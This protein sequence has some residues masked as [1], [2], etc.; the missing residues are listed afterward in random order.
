MSTLPKIL[1]TEDLPVSEAKWV[2]L[3]KIH[4]SDPTG[5]KRVWECAQ[6]KTTGATGI[7]AVAIL[8]MI[9]S[10]TN[11][12]PPSTV[13]VTQFRPP[14]GKYAVELPAGLIDKGETAEE[15]AVRELEEE[16]GFK[17][18][19][20]LDSSPLLVCDPGMTTATMKII[21]VDVP[22]PDKLEIPVQKLDPGE[23][24]DVRVVE[25]PKLV[26]ELRDY[27]AKGYVVDARLAHFAHGYELAERYRNAAL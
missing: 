7:D 8:A 17:G 20:I 15:A 6:R 25:L 24:I 27:E 2:T 23:F 12:F 11:V 26:A 1:S 22:L 18:K 3:K 14:I 5:K 16:T 13:I 4:W 10:E 21:I 9:R 19:K